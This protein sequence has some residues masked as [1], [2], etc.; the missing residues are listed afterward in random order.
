VLAFAST[1]LLRDSGF[2]LWD[3]GGTDSS[4]MMAYKREVA[5]EQPRTLAL[6]RRV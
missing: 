4:P 6:Q 1:R 3:L 2:A 5:I